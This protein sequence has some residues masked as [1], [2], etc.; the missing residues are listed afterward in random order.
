MWWKLDGVEL[1]IEVI[2]KE[3]RRSGR[4]Q[5]RCREREVA[6]KRRDMWREESEQLKLKI[7]ELEG[8]A[9]KRD[10]HE[11]RNNIVIRGKKFQ[12]KRRWNLRWR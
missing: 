1:I 9:K 2:R 3:T 12:E 7:V 10:R 4:R 6:A 5:E 8:Q 11:R